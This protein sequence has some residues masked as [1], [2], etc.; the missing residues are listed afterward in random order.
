M[1]PPFEPRSIGQWT[2]AYF[3][4]F[5]PFLPAFWVCLLDF[6]LFSWAVVFGQTVPNRL[7][8]MIP[9]LKIP[10]QGSNSWAII[11]GL[12]LLHPVRRW[13]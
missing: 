11:A 3:W 4:E 12:A 2:P 6:W 10:I 9:P 1:L 13:G 5:S 8:D 7:R